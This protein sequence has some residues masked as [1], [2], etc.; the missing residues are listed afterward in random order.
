MKLDSKDIYRINS[1]DF[2]SA[3]LLSSLFLLY[4]PLIGFPA[5]SLYVT[6]Y[7]EG[8]GQHT[9][10]AHS[11]LLQLTG[12][13]IEELEQARLKLEEYVLV[14]TYVQQQ[15]TRCSYLYVINPPLSTAGFLANRELAG[16]LTDAIGRKGVEEL[17][18]RTHQT[19]ISSD[20]RNITRAV[21]HAPHQR[22]VD[23][24]VTFNTPSPRYHFVDNDTAINFDYD[25][26]LALTDNLVFPAELRTEENLRLIGQLATVYG[27][28]PAKMNIL[29]SHSINL[30]T[31]QFD[32]KRLQTLCQKSQPD[33]TSAKDPYDLP[34]VSF[35]QAKM[36]GK[37]VSNA[38][39][40]ILE[41]LSVQMKFA[42]DVINV[43]IEYILKTSQNR[44][45]RQFVELVASTWARDGVTTRAQA[46]AETRKQLTPG[47]TAASRK[48][49]PAYYSQQADQQK[50]EEA[51][52]A[53]E[54]RQIQELQK[55][56]RK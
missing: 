10:F 20:Y 5:A 6:L 43:M 50:E 39:R 44:L 35:L 52:S 54:L 7:T 3:D 1:G 24:H 48:Q 34:P 33:I 2:L 9:Q 8:R 19:T 51:P 31:M 27:L 36:N 55:K 32:A 41:Y 30:E 38:E 45:V 17:L 12:M 49:M 28:S 47:R 46:L 42:P 23:Y 40:Q 13:N 53:E 16:L 37:P 4:Q 11:R 14:S 22:D 56:M 29:V 15:D 18:T 26:F 21:S 25:R